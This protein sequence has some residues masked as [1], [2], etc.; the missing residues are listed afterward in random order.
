MTAGFGGFVARARAAGRLVVQPRMGF[1]D[2]ATMRAGLL[3]T[4]RVPATTVG[5]LTL[6]SY[7][8]VNDIASADR[9]LAEGI[10]LNGY[11]IVSYGPERTTTVL[12]GIRDAGFPV[13]VRHG[14]ARPQDIVRASLAAGLDATEGGPVSYC[15]PYSRMPLRDAVRN[16]SHTAE[17][18]VSAPNAHVETFGGCML[19][20][21]C[22][23]SMLVALSVLEGLFFVQHGLRSVSL[24]Y[25]QQVD[26]E[27]DEEA[28]HALRRLAADL[29][30]GVDWH[31][32]VYTYMG[33]YPTTPHGAAALL[34]SS[35]RLAVRSGAARL[36][37]KT[38]AEARRIPTIAE[39]VDALTL[40]AE[41]A[42]ATRWADAEPDAADTTVHTEA[43]AIVTAVLG[44]A[45]TVAE[46]LPAA[47]RLGYLDI[48]YCLHPDNAGR[49]TSEIDPTGRLRWAA[50][51][52]LPFRA[53]P[54]VA[55]RGPTSAG[56]L[57]ALSH[58]QRRFD[59]LPATA[60]PA[61]RPVLGAQ[62]TITTP[63]PTSTYLPPS[64]PEHLASPVTRAALRV[65]Q[66][67]LTAARSFLSGDGFIELL[68][69]VIGPVTDPGVRGSKQLDVDYYGHR[70]KLMTSGI[71]YKQASLLAFDKLFFIA[72]NVRAEPV[73]TC[74]TR[75]HLAEFH[76]I[77]VEISGGTRA[78][79]RRLAERLL[80]HVVRHVLR[81]A[82]DDLAALGR[83]PVVFAELLRE[84]FDVLTHAEAVAALHDLQYPQSTDAEIEWEGEE[85]LSH[86]ARRPFFVTDYPKGSRGFYDRENPESPGTLR[87]FD[88]IVP[89]GYGEL[90]SGSERESDYAT[91]V[92][93]MRETGENPAKYKWYLDMVRDGIP[94]SAGFGMGLERLTRF[95]TG[96][97]SVWQVN[98][99][100]KVPGLVAP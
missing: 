69:P 47:F 60:G 30:P 9:A 99:Y 19:G 8:R 71:L 24:S 42:A 2:T 81:T 57:A 59:R 76:Q 44:L 41:V 62:M 12:D 94:A 23:P 61:D 40:A 25:A 22:P 37:V 34:E 16:W 92:T 72:P 83:D 15:L 89:G 67:V 91:I 74:N 33:L 84:P 63:G 85:L 18:L 28:V 49:T 58:T 46:A 4:K 13:Q 38:A 43:R 75:R 14:S 32:V 73:E 96:L 78:D 98:A 82:G 17:I 65:Q 87:N 51:G 56:L 27:Q 11:P 86:K 79:A 77:D 29:L 88:L 10:P 1:S 5:T 52:S 36:I 64:P 45:D 3:A 70:Y 48:P 68:P 35:A 53:R 66:Q 21:L 97:D 50:T 54:A 39:N 31:V 90:V 26:A 55:G 6:D 100:P 80:V 93:R 95:L 7:T 20:Q